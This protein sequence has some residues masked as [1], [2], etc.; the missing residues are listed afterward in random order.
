MEQRNFTNQH[1][2]D[3]GPLALYFQG[4]IRFDE[5]GKR[6]AARTQTYVDWLHTKKSELRHFL[7]RN[8]ATYAQA[9]AFIAR[10]CKHL[11]INRAEFSSIGQ[12]SE[13]E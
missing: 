13:A 1:N 11:N 10:W 3:M 7:V 2:T 6:D 8:N 12:T 4:N 9:D 5:L